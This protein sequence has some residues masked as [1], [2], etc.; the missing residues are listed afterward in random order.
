M[1]TTSFRQVLDTEAELLLISPIKRDIK[2]ER[3]EPISV[4]TVLVKI[5]H[6]PKCELE[7]LRVWE[8]NDSTSIKCYKIISQTL[9]SST[10]RLQT[11]NYQKAGYQVR[12]L[13]LNQEE[14][15]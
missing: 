2:R 8:G 6:A 13:I 14:N 5:S 12:F 7:M 1:G 4:I 3:A 9:E 11:C 15:L 10:F